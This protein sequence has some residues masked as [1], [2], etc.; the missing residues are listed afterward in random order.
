MSESDGKVSYLSRKLSL[1]DTEIVDLRRHL[2]NATNILEGLYAG[3]VA[4]TLT[5]ADWERVR[6]FVSGDDI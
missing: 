4:G 3:H 2:D 1:K 6:I 5:R